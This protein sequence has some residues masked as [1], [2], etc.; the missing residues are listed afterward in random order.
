M[1]WFVSKSFSSRF[2]VNEL[3]LQFVFESEKNEVWFPDFQC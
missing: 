2:N 1:P 3:D